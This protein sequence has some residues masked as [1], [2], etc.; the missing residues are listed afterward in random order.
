[1]EIGRNKMV[2]LSYELRLNSVDG[3]VVEKTD[4]ITSYSIHYTK[5]YDHVCIVSI[6]IKLQLI[7]CVI[8]GFIFL[9]YVII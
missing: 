7:I 1:M 3:E 6:D 4:V 9:D 2:T 8:N 5:L